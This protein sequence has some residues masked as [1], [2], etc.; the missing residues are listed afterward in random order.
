MIMEKEKLRVKI[1]ETM[2]SKRSATI[3][4]RRI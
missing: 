3:A 4:E 1:S 2:K